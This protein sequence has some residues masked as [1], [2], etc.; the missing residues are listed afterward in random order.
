MRYA[1]SA[2]RCV[3]H[4]VPLVPLP[5]PRLGSTIAGRYVLESVIGEGGMAT[6]YRARLKHGGRP[7]A[8]KV[9]S[10][11]LLKDEKLRARF[12]REARLASALVHPNVVSV[13]DQGEL[14]DGCPYLVL[15]LLEGEK[16]EEL[17]QRGPI[18]VSRA[19]LLMLQITHAVAR[20]HDLGIL[21]RD[22]KPENVYVCKDVHGND[23]VKVIDFGIA[24]AQDDT[25]ITESG[26]LFGTPQY[27]SPARIGGE[28]HTP[29]DDLYALGVMFFEMSTGRLPFQASDN[30]TYFLKQLHELPPPPISL[31][32]QL[33]E[34]LNRLIVQLLEKKAMSRPADARRVLSELTSMMLDM[35]QEPPPSVTQPFRREDMLALRTPAALVEPNAWQERL[36]ELR[37]QLGAGDPERLPSELRVQLTCAEAL[38]EDLTAQRESAQKLEAKFEQQSDEDFV[39]RHRLGAAVDQLGG[40]LSR[41]REIARETLAARQPL[42]AAVAQAR[43]HAHTCELTLRTMGGEHLAARAPIK[44]VSALRALAEAIEAW[45]EPEA[46]LDALDAKSAQQAAEQADLEQQIEQLRASMA[47]HDAGAAAKAEALGE[48]LE[49][50]WAK[51]QELEAAT[52]QALRDLQELVAAQ[53]SR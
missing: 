14:E 2:K 53:S 37:A 26:E 31:N 22:L 36:A 50:S 5:D 19:L 16:L 35:E 27:L 12:E 30:T 32:S 6:V 4:K 38:V 42:V 20:A 13:E 33:P 11:G 15:E 7:V 40:Q 39:A 23:H 45:A 44:V 51:E 41:M 48:E 25:R 46:A 49:A 43:A 21:H 10:Q 9:M 17:V 1:E 34:R 29:S 3:L 8:V 28:D 47:N 24:R 18:P 52:M